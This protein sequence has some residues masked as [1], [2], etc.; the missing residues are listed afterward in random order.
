M[1]ATTDAGPRA[2]PWHF[3][4]V[5]VVAALWNGFGAYDY[6]MSNTQGEAYFRQ[7]GMTDAQISYMAGYPTWMMAVWAIGIWGS[8]LGVLLLILRRKWAF[9]AFA[10][11]LAAIVVS[12]VYTYGMSNGAE[13]M[14]Q[15]GMIMQALI[16]A[17]C[18]FFAWYSRRMAAQGLLR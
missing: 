3:W 6:I 10:V 5:V 18:A 15:V 7:M 8:V 14:G 1:T 17:A 4:V 9:H 16:T 2:T 13:V 12:L 11:S